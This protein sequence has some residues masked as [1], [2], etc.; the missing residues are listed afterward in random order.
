MNK[1]EYK[2]VMNDKFGVKY[3]EAVIEI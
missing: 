2:K 3:D 1:P